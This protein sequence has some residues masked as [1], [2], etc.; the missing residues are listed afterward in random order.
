MHGSG[1][2]RS[3]TRVPEYPW[4]SARIAVRGSHG[5]LRPGMVEAWLGYLVTLIHGAA[6]PAVL[7]SWHYTDPLVNVAELATAPWLAG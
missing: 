1:I 2:L 7:S 3:R 5:L 4:H 6:V